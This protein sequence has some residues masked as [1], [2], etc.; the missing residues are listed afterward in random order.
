MFRKHTKYATYMALNSFTVSMSSVLT[1]H[2]M[3][4]SITVPSALTSITITYVGKDILGQIGGLVYSWKSGKLA[5]KFP[6]KHVTKASILQ[7]GSFFM[8]NM[9]PIF[10]MENEQ[11]LIPY[12]GLTNILKNISFISMGAVNVKN[13]QKISEEKN[14]GELYSKITSILTLSSS[15]GMLSGITLITLV[16]SYTV[17]TFVI[18]PVLNILNVY[19]CRK[20]TQS[21]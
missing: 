7:Q 9:A 16:P 1:T 21:V 11:L 8:E 18:M 15:L 5:D 19:T 13:L 12:F 2:N 20:A 4:S 14:L 6:V 10:H 3:L 17:R